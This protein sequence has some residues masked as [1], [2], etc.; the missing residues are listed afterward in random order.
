MQKLIYFALGVVTGGVGVY[1]YMKHK[2]SK[3]ADAAIEAIRDIQEKAE[4]KIN[5]AVDKMLYIAEL[6]DYDIVDLDFLDDPVEFPQEDY[7]K[8]D[9]LL[10]QY[11]KEEEVEEFLAE[12]EHP[13]DSHED[14]IF[15]EYSEDVKSIEQEDKD[16]ERNE[17]RAEMA[18]TN[19]FPA[20]YPINTEV[21]EEGE[22][23]G[24]D[25]I[26]LTYFELDKTL[27]D[28]SETPVSIEETIGSVNLD[29]HWGF[30][31]FPKDI[32]VIRNTEKQVDYIVGRMIASYHDVYYKDRDGDILDDQNRII[33]EGENDE[34]TE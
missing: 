22:A 5:R 7:D 21:Y 24:F 32:V 28:D 19:S 17:I 23:E 34:R 29:T 16:I 4:R 11:H 13:M 12:R 10:R 3:D 1:A 8:Y 2:A 31:D 14:D 6:A 18:R 27:I 33:P 20:P 15:P 26:N 30:G 9:E 25:K